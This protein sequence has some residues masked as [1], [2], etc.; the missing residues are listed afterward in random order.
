[1]QARQPSFSI[2][3]SARRRVLIHN[4]D[5]CEVFRLASAKG[6]AEAKSQISASPDR[7]GDVPPD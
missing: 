4:A 7:A 1:M 6:L 5:A 2:H 3:S